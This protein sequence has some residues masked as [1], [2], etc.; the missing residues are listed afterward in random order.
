LK[1][2]TGSVQRLSKELGMYAEEQA[3][4]AARVAKMRESNAD[5]HDI[6][7]AE[8]VLAEAAMM[9]PDTRQRLEVAL[10]DLQSTLEEAAEAASGT[11]ELA[12]AQSAAQKAESLLSNPP[13]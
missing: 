9:I 3:T 13:P 12:V 6:Q 7:H 8:N 11:E 1:I 5:S 10:Q 4:E 2:K